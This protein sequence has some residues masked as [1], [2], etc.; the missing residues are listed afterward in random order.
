LKLTSTATAPRLVEAGVTHDTSVDETIFACDSVVFEVPNL[1][2]KEPKKP[3]PST[4]IVFPP[5]SP[6]IDGIRVVTDGAT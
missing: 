1:H 6:P 3:D 4:E 2:T 5:S